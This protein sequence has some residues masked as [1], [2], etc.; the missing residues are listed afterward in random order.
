VSE[1]YSLLYST[2]SFGGLKL[3]DYCARIVS[4]LV[5]LAGNISLRTEL[6]SVHLQVK[7]AAS[8]GLILTELTTNAVKYAFPAGRKGT[9]TVG[10]KKTGDGKAM[11]EVVDDGVGFPIGFDLASQAGLGLN[12]VQGLAEQ[13]GGIFTIGKG[14]TGTRCTLEFGIG[15]K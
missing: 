11:L 13:I 3:D 7:N 15:P 10:L 14:V 4:P 5:A 12:L 1:L 2:G 8:I 9:V 6:E